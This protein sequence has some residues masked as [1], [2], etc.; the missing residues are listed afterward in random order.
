MEAN[1]GWQYTPDPPAYIPQRAV[2]N[3]P[4]KIVNK[5]QRW[6]EKQEN[7]K[8]DKEKDKDKKSEP[9]DQVY[10]VGTMLTI[11]AL[12]T[13]PVVYMIWHLSTH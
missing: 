1:M 13:G 2:D 11:S 8:K 9:W 3:D 10:Q 12:I 7:K 6:L 5:F 4:L